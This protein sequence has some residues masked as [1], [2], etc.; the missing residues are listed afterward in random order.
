MFPSKSAIKTWFAPVRFDSNPIHF[1]QEMITVTSLIYPVA[2]L[3]FKDGIQYV[4]QV[5]AFDEYHN[6]LG[7]NQGKSEVWTFT[8]VEAK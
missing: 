6:P 8:F 4:W 3:P 1:N 7:D 5:Q 2:G